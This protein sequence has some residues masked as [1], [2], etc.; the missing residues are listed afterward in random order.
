[1]KIYSCLC[2]FYLEANLIGN[3]QALIIPGSDTT[4]VSLQWLLLAMASFPDIQDKVQEEIDTGLEEN[5]T[6]FWVD[7]NRFPYCHA[8]ILEGQRW[9]T[10][11]P[12]NLT[13]K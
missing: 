4:K 5:E 6:V 7:R 3:V 11:V 13:H 12:V 8:T 10:V 9:R 2:H 1:M